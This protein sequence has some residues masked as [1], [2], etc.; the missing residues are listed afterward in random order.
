[1]MRLDPVTTSENSNSTQT[2]EC[3]HGEAK[4]RDLKNEDNMELCF[5]HITFVLNAWQHFYGQ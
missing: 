5:I 4:K 3:E 2:I 1:M